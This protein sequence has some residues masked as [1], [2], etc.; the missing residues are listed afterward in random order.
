MPTLSQMPVAT[1]TTTQQ[2]KIAPALRT[3]LRKALNIYGEL[4]GQEKAL[5]LAKDKC[6]SSIEDVL[7]DIGESSLKIDGFST[8]MV[9]PVRTVLDEKKLIEQ[10]V[11]IEQINAAKVQVATKPYIKVTCPG[12]DDE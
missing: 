10:G 4:K 7:G 2:V 3:K 1:T 6:R 9:A 12:G 5:K 8:T 11:T